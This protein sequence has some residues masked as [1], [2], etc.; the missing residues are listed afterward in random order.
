MV[1][2]TCNPSYLGGERRRIGSLRSTQV[3]LVKPYFKNKNKRAEGA[4]PWVQSPVPRKEGK[5]RAESGRGKRRKKGKR[6]GREEEGRREEG[7]GGGRG[8]PS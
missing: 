8:D 1:V 7:R 6:K 4:R 3:N 2:H 5:G